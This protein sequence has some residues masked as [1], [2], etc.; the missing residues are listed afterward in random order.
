M[1][2]QLLFAFS[3]VAMITTNGQINISENF[4]N[5]YNDWAN[6][7]SGRDRFVVS[8]I[9]VC[10]GSGAAGAMIGSILGNFGVGPKYMYSPLLTNN[11]GNDL[12][13]QYSVMIGQA[14]ATLTEM[15]AIPSEIDWGYM[16]VAYSTDNG[17][18][19]TEIQTL[20]SSNYTSKTTCE[21]YHLIIPSDELSSLN[22]VI[23]RWEVDKNVNHDELMM[24]V[25]DD[26]MVNQDALSTHDVMKSKVKIYPN[27]TSDFVQ[28]E[29]NDVIKVVEIY[30]PAGVL[31][32]KVF[33]TNYIEIKDLPRGNYFLKIN[34]SLTSKFMKK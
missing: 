4:E 19:W 11:N 18:S 28:I 10:N 9:Y 13:I 3:L 30:N 25:I 20:N 7:E 33:N 22:P 26:V 2:K 16:K 8:E 34:D 31:V 24:Y 6:P 5:P 23:L 21:P 1:R 15:I 29:I 17:S 32:K 27:P 14:N 12:H